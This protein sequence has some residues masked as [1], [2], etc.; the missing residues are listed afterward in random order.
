MKKSELEEVLRWHVSRYPLMGPTDVLKLLY[1]GEFGGGHLASDP[2]RCLAALREEY[3]H[4]PPKEDV[5]LTEPLGG[6]LVRLN[7][8]AAV[9]RG[10]PAEEVGEAFL[11]SAEQVRGDFGRFAEK[12]ER[13]RQLPEEILPFARAELEARLTSYAAQGFPPCSHSEEY[14][15]AYRPAYRVLLKSVLRLKSR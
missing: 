3:A 9:R 15:R 7:L 14:R 11:R 10:I 8:A 13:L 4:T 12:L 6:D 5:P 2:E 1:Q